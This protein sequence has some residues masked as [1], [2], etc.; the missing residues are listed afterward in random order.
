MEIKEIIKWLKKKKEAQKEIKKEDE[1]LSKLYKE[2]ENY[3]PAD[4][5]S[6]RIKSIINKI[7]TNINGKKIYL[8]EGKIHIIYFIFFIL[9]GGIIFSLFMTPKIIITINVVITSVII[10]F[11]GTLITILLK[12]KLSKLDR[13]AKR[14]SELAQAKYFESLVKK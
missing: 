1:N 4:I 8:L 5:V 2:L 13:E 10:I 11:I 6:D 7:Q 9:G 14:K 3:S 12:H